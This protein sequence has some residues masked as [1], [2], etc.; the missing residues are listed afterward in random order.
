M[1]VQLATDLRPY[2]D[3]SGVR[4]PLVADNLQA[5]NEPTA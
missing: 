3:G 2:A 1:A 4:I 5:A